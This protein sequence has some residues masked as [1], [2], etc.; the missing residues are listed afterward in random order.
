MV[1]S[2]RK[3]NQVDLSE[4]LYHVEEKTWSRINRA[5]VNRANYY[6]NL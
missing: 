3:A 5:D 1:L 6:N 2:K 4:R